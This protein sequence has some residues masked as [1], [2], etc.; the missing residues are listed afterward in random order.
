MHNGPAV[1]QVFCVGR[2]IPPNR[3]IILWLFV[4]FGDDGWATAGPDRY[5]R[6]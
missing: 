5:Y 2:T 4:A 3:V 6:E 1:E